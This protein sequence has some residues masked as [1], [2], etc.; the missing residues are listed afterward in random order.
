MPKPPL[1]SR[2][3]VPSDSTVAVVPPRRLKLAALSVI[4]R[5]AAEPLR[6]SLLVVVLSNTSVAVGF[7]VVTV[8]APS[9]PAP[10]TT[11]VPRLTFVAPE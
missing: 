11:S 8:V 1:T 5:A 4:P 3:P 7:T 6:A 2:L 10:L 9:R